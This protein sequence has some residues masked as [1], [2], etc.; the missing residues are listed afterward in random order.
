ML[1]AAPS[2]VTAAG[3][4]QV[5]GG[6]G[7]GVITLITTSPASPVAA[8]CRLPGCRWATAAA[9]TCGEGVAGDDPAA[10]PGAPAEAGRRLVCRTEPGVQQSIA[11]SSSLPLLPSSPSRLADAARRAWCAAPA[12]AA[13]LP[14]V[15]W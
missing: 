11:K 10:G 2:P 13:V 8:C 14:G 6:E 7:D 3:W 5:S 1:G 15:R 12:P 9:A 4:Q